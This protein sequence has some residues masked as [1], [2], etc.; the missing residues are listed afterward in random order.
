MMNSFERYAYM[1]KMPQARSEAA[2]IMVT[3]WM[4]VAWPLP[5]FEPSGKPENILFVKRSA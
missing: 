4:F 1:K 2:T 3:I 5:P